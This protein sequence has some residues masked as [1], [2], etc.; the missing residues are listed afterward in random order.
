MIQIS[1]RTVLKLQGYLS[2]WVLTG[3]L[4][5]PHLLTF[6]FLDVSW[7]TTPPKLRDNVRLTRATALHTT[8]INTALDCQQW[9]QYGRFRVRNLRVVLLHNG[10]LSLLSML[11]GRKGGF[12]ALCMK[13]EP[14]RHEL[15]WAY[16]FWPST[17][18]STEAFEQLKPFNKSQLQ[19]LLNSPLL[20]FHLGKLSL[21]CRCKLSQDGAMDP[22]S[23]AVG[24][25]L[26]LFFSLHLLTFWKMKNAE[27]AI[28]SCWC[29][30]HGCICIC[31]WITGRLK[32]T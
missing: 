12:Q 24:Y 3:Y 2:L 4:S 14:Y 26:S 7:S 13:S 29:C 9:G 15:L 27:L 22:V 32:G 5:S 25:K 28:S 6:C 23:Y 19:S 8:H 20:H 11:A 30:V 1:S 18:C 21:T 10:T 31:Q 17:R 16:E